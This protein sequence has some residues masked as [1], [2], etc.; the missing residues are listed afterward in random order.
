M[1]LEIGGLL[2]NMTTNNVTITIIQHLIRINCSWNKK[3]QYQP[4]VKS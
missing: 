3:I 2:F 4:L 1:Q